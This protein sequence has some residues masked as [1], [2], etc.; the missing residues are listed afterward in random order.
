MIQSLQPAIKALIIDMD[1]VLW[2]SEQPIG[3]LPRLFARI[4]QLELRTIFA[5][6]NA[7]RTIDQY[8]HR[9]GRFGIPAVPDQIIT[10]AI[11]TAHFLKQRFPKGGPVFIIG[12]IGLTEAL[13]SCGF[14]AQDEDVLAVV[15]GLDRTVTYEKL[16][17]A[18][19]LIHAG[20]LFYGT[21]PDTTLPTP[22][23]PAMGAGGILAA[24]QTS[25]DVQPVISGKPYTPMMDMVLEK[26]NLPPAEILAVGDRLNTD[27]QAG[28]NIGCKTALVLTG[29]STRSEAEAWNPPP[30]LIAEDFTAL[31]G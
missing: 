4:R 20:A 6:N 1:G 5:T 23:G 18:T 9:L 15:A 16:S 24:I 17:Q 10:S 3:D 30:D 8:V 22:Q 26:L 11:A 27:I 28:Q 7:T 21:N 13:K 12:E 14:Y 31:I 2:R 29:I 25:T 19:H